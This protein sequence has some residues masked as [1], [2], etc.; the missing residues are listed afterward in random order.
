LI[1]RRAGGRVTARLTGHSHHDLNLWPRARPCF[2]ASCAG[3]N[4]GMTKPLSFSTALCS[5]I[6][7]GDIAAAP[8]WIHLIPSGEV[9]THDGRGPYRVTDAAA[10]MASSLGL[11]SKL[12]LDENHATDLA[13]PKGGE[14]PARGWIVDL[15]QRDDG[16]WGRVEW[17]GTG[18]AKIED[19]EYRGVSPVIAHRADGTITHILRAS[20]VN[21]P[22][23]RGLQALHMEH[24]M[25]FRVKLIEA[26]GLDSAA[27]DAAIMAAIKAKLD[28]GSEGVAVA[29]Q[30]AL[31]PIA[32][33]IGLQASADAAAVLAGVQKL[34]AGPGDVIVELQSALTNV[35][36]ELNTLR[37][38]TAKDKATAFVDGAIAAGRVGV[39][40]LRDRYISMHA[41]D[42]A[43]TAELVN[44]MPILKPGAALPTTPGDK[45]SEGAETPQQ[46]AAHA[47]T[48]QKKLAADGVTIDFAV[49]V[50]AV[51]EG[52][53]K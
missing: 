19:K 9:M 45:G 10:M 31:A 23:F 6:A 13:A 49:A 42:P 3:K 12:V 33:F 44:A 48:Y 24:N 15:Q 25:D 20:L 53:H 46:I 4:S 14:A 29:V 28:G 40:P 41:K 43:G 2:D 47:A 16:I 21:Q 37:D 39:K 26:L 38:D 27:D 11:A 50:R 34:K 22:N 17:T 51:Q 52:K 1:S 35:T 36:T 7:L 30:S 5:A 18:R 8:E 32:Q